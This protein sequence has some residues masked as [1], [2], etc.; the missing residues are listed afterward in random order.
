[1]GAVRDRVVALHRG[2]MKDREIA[3]AIGM[4][5]ATVQ[6]HLSVAR[7]VGELD[8]LPRVVRLKN[9]AAE[10]ATVPASAP[11]ASQ[12]AVIAAPVTLSQIAQK[13]GT[14]EPAQIPTELP[15]DPALVLRLDPVTMAALRCMAADRA[16]SVQAMG[17]AVIR[18][19]VAGIIER[20]RPQTRRAVVPVIPHDITG[21]LMGDPQPGRVAP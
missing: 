11:V 4:R 20:I 10:P 9:G 15:A 19:A 3:A 16:M 6:V 1:M 18:D 12:P 13:I 2:G 21:T 7:K 8:R 14:H 5:L 17:R